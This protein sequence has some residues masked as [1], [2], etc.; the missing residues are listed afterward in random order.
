[1]DRQRLAEENLG[2]AYFMANRQ[3]KRW[4]KHDL[5]ELESTALEGL[6]DAARTWKPEKGA[7]S[8]YACRCI[9]N[10]YA[11]QINYEHRQKRDG[12]TV[13]LDARRRLD[14]TEAEYTFLES[15][16]G[17][18]PGPEKTVVEREWVREALQVLSDRQKAIVLM[19]CG[20]FGPI[21]SIGQIAERFGTSRKAVQSGWERAL[22]RIRTRLET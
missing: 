9:Q 19:R 22:Q 6:W 17:S 4:E 12:I 18:A 20:F 21:M 7:F 14:N 16:A 2:L 10:A 1:M 15:L 3:K 8:T 13:S 5:E 11:K